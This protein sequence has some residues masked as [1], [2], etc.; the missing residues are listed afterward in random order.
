MVK[1]LKRSHWITWLPIFAFPKSKT[2]LL[3][4]QKG[5]EDDFPIGCWCQV[6]FWHLKD[7]PKRLGVPRYLWK[8]TRAHGIDLGKSWCPF[9]ENLNDEIEEKSRWCLRRAPCT[10]F[11]GW[12]MAKPSAP[13]WNYCAL[14]AVLRPFWPRTW[15]PEHHR[16]GQVRW[17]SSSTGVKTTLAEISSTA[18]SADPDAAMEVQKQILLELRGLRAEANAKRLK[19]SQHM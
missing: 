13:C 4:L 8:G 12:S 7:M 11:T 1:L 19:T 16:G 3:H 15:P 6:C 9:S 5:S 17:P 10:S 14:L 18:N 2:N